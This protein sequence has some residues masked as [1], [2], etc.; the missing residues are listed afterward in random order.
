[1]LDNSV[2]TK[3]DRETL[4]LYHFRMMN[5]LRKVLDINHIDT[6]LDNYD[7]YQEFSGWAKEDSLSHLKF[8][9]EHIPKGDRGSLGGF[10]D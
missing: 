10:F 4:Q 1:M 6:I 5:L 3:V 9:D 2:L 7:V 8:A